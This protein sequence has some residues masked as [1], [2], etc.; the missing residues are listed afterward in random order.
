MVDAKAMT[1]GLVETAMKATKAM[2]Q[3]VAVPELSQM[4]GLE[5]RQ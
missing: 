3:T 4:L 1:E 5:A 2:V